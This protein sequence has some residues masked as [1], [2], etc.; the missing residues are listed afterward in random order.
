[1]SVL[2]WSASPFLQVVVFFSGVFLVRDAE[3]QAG[4]LQ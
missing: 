4:D 1:M 3:E 2:I